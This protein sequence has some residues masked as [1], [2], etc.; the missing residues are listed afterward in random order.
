MPIQSTPPS[1]LEYLHSASASSTGPITVN[2]RDYFEV[3]NSPLGSL[4]SH[5]IP[6]MYLLDYTTGKYMRISKSSSLILGYPAQT[7]LD[8]GVEFA[9]KQF[10]PEH[11][12]LLNKKI[13]PDRFAFLQAIRPEQHP[14]YV[15]TYNLSLKNRKN[16]YKNF[17]QRNIFIKSDSNGSPLLSLGMVVNIDNYP[18]R[19]VVSHKIERVDS[20]VMLDSPALVSKTNYFLRDEQ[21][22]L[23][24]REIEILSLL[25]D[26]KSSKEIANRLFISEG[27]VNIHRKNMLQKTNCVNV[28]ALVAYGARTHLI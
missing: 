8:G 5:T 6:M 11:L 27:T 25:A 14:N 21:G 20:N 28:A 15:F 1:W 16:E 18:T 13:F 24:K 7:Y 22:Q 23:T 12:N 3:L 4:F 19:H 9:A 2:E 10:H 17:I 26:G